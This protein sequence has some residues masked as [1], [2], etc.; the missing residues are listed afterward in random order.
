M[1]A[2][3]AF[4]IT[5]CGVRRAGRT[6]RDPP[7]ALPRGLGARVGV[8]TA[9]IIRPKSRCTVAGLALPGAAGGR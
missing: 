1:G 9:A 2:G 6:P 5:G 4:L 8:P 3:L 7:G